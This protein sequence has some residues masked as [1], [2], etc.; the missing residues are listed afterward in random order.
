LSLLSIHPINQESA[1]LLFCNFFQVVSVV[2]HYYAA[3][4]AA[5]INLRRAIIM[6]RTIVLAKVMPNGNVWHVCWDKESNVAEEYHPTNPD[7]RWKAEV[8]LTDNTLTI[9]IPWFEGA[10]AKKEL[11]PCQII[12][13]KQAVCDGVVW[14]KGAEIYA[15]GSQHEAKVYVLADCRA[16][17]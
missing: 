12:A 7:K 2:F 3:K 1:Q 8:S 17:I 10:S 16:L 9:T 5:S 6:A 4:W 11:F 13:K 14:F 15:T